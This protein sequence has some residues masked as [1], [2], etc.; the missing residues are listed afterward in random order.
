MTGKMGRGPRFLVGIG[1]ALLASAP[2][3]AATYQIGLFQNGA[4]TGSGSFNFNNP[5]T[6]G[7]TPVAVADLA[8]NATSPIGARNF[9]AGSLGVQVATVNF[10]DGKT[11]P[12]QISGNFVEGLTGPL[13]TAASTGLTPTGQCSN[14]VCFYRITFSFTANSNPN[15]AAKTYSIQLVRQQTG[16]N[17]GNPINGTYSVSNIATIPEPGTLALFALGL[18]LLA[19]WG[20]TRSRR[21][22]GSAAA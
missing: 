6:V 9:L 15:L 11:P 2:A 19:G 1:L 14:Q 21:L 5:G 13:Q 3:L 17:V 12:N 7:S 4:G 16:N 20:A 22:S 18:T 8:T 10:N